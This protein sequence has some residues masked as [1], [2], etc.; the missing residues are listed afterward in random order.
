MKNMFFFQPLPAVFHVRAPG[1][2][3]AEEEKLVVFC[4]F[5]SLLSNGRAD[6]FPP[7]DDFP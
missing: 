1:R 6:K 2:Q 3:G 5:L 4:I 7:V